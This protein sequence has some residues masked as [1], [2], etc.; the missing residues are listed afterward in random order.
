[1]ARCRVNVIILKEANNHWI[2]R[3]RVLHLFAADYNLI[4]GVKWRHLLRHAESHQTLNDGQYG[5]RSGREATGLNLLEVLKNE[6]SHCSRKALLS[7]DNDASS[8]YDHIIV[9]LSS[10]I[11]R[12][13]GQHRQIVLVNA[14]TLK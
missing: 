11:N 1:M 13:Y 3:L 12:K 5:S 10:L 2:H 7:L 4:L 14:S 9:A 6:I 8:C